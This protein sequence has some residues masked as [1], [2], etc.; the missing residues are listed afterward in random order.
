MSGCFKMLYEEFKKEKL[1]EGAVNFNGES[2][3]LEMLEDYITLNDLKLS[4]HNSYVFISTLPTIN[5]MNFIK[6]MFYGDYKCLILMDLDLDYFKKNKCQ[7]S[8][9][10]GFTPTIPYLCRDISLYKD[11]T[12]TYDEARKDKIKIFGLMN[13]K[14]Q[15]DWLSQFNE[16][17]ENF[18]E[19]DSKY[20]SSGLFSVSTV[21]F[22]E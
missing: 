12:E 7:R 21:Y 5:E 10:L 3:K 8:E 2:F 14:N 20:I 11:I 18:S 22:L 6:H 1:R 16:K 19:E 9:L 17:K 13:S 4:L 15:I